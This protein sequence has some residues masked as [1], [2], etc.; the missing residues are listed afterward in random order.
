MYLPNSG[1]D[2]PDGTAGTIGFATVAKRPPSRTTFA[3]TSAIPPIPYG[4]LTDTA[5]NTLRDASGNRRVGRDTADTDPLPLKD[6]VAGKGML[7]GTTIQGDAAMNAPG[8]TGYATRKDWISANVDLFVPGSVMMPDNFNPADG[9][10][11]SGAINNFLS[12]ARSRGKLVRAHC[13]FYPKRDIGTWIDR[14][15]QQDPSRWQTL[16]SARI[17][18]LASVLTPYTDIITN[19]DGIN[20][21][22]TSSNVNPGG[23]RT[24]PWNTAVATLAGRTA[25]TATIDDYLTPCVFALSRLRSRLPGIDIYWCNDLSE[26]QG[27]GTFLTYGANVRAG[28][29][30]ARDAGAPVDG[31][32]SQGHLQNRLAFSAVN[33]RTFY[34]NL[35]VT[36]G[37]KLI[38]GE[39]DTH[40]GSSYVPKDTRY[41]SEYSILEYDRI[42]ADMVKAFL[43]V[44]LPFIVSSG[45]GQLVSW[46]LDDGYNAWT[47]AFGEPAGERPCPYDAAYQP[48]PQLT[49]IRNAL[50]EI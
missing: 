20:E 8:P 16:L 45:G 37:L 40:T 41:P 27:S 31:Y 1:F 47:A 42:S 39:L 28:I 11:N 35:T 17:D 24:N 29:Q 36:D 13:A 12:D 34:R 49:A 43:D 50:L 19:I 5:A 44:A 15:L 23:W 46:T 26:Q 48:K 14:A 32:N 21:V 6:L 33:L 38:V 22:F 4:A 18:F 30:Q 3:P 7:Y 10:F 25:A 9:T 2:I